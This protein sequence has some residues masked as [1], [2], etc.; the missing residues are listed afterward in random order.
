MQLVAMPMAGLAGIIPT[1][2][3]LSPYQIKGHHLMLLTQV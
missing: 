3:G 2:L 1:T